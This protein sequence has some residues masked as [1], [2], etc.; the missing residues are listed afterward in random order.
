VVAS[1]PSPPRARAGGL[2]LTDVGS[3]PLGRGGAFV[4]G[5]DDPSA[6][7]YN[8][9][10]LGWA[11]MQLTLSASLPVVDADFTRIDSGGATLPTDSARAAPIPIPALF[12]ADDFGLRD[13]T[14]GAGVFAPTA[15]SLSWSDAVDA[16]ARYSLVTMDGTALVHLA[17]GAAWRP[18][19]QLSIGL[20]AHLV[21]G[22]FRAVTTLSACDRAICAQPENPEY[23]ARAELNLSPVAAPTFGLGITYDAG[24][25]RIGASA[26]TGYAL[27]GDATMRVR[28]PSAA[29]FDGARVDGD[30][31]AM[32]LDL[33]WILRAGVEVR[34]IEGL[35][36]EAAAV[37]ELWSSQGE[38]TV[39][40]RDVWLRN[41]TAIGDYEVGPIT[42]PRAMR[43]TLS[44]RLGGEYRAGVLAARAGLAYEN[45]AFD[46]A[47]LSP[48]TLDSDR[49]MP[50]V[51]ASV[52]VTRA[53]FVDA[54]FV[55]VAMRD[56]QVRN[57]AVPQ[58]N[59]IRPPPVDPVYVGNGDYAMDAMVFAL[60]VRWAPGEGQADRAPGR[61]DGDDEGSRGGRGE[62]GHVE[63]GHGDADRSHGE[64]GIGHGG[65]TPAG[66]DGHATGP[67]T[68]E[69][70]PTMG[71]ATGAATGTRDA[72]GGAPEGAATPAAG[73][74][75]PGAD[76]A[77][78]ALPRSR[79]GRGAP[80]AADDPPPADNPYRDIARRGRRR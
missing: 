38:I 42:I 79:R 40:P 26:Q 21:V 23:D 4:A 36:V 33:P 46:D 59:P 17:L 32:S 48:L 28:I 24:P 41:V 52:E 45:G 80:R 16:P 18:V 67:G 19:P 29:V 66:T 73:A 8:P 57:S 58:A 25:V 7:W 27:S 60:G 39:R 61:G 13:V 75:S 12:Y 49:W 50:S 56:R 37:A 20:G 78:S 31:G 71:A 10:G 74:A 53:L 62:G 47:T 2:Y 11:G 35:R 76:G 3:R 70:A 44:L 22:G 65:A 9:A 69:R 51:G 5:A 77:P 30:R 15:L 43:D 6:L 64:G 63:E 54:A 14:F 34:P 55:Y 68:G 1:S 72:P